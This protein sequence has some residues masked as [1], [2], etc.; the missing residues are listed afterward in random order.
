MALPHTWYLLL[1]PSTSAQPLGLRVA[2]VMT[3]TWEL[4]TI[5]AHEGK[6]EVTHRIF[7]FEAM[8]PLSSKNTPH[9][10]KNLKL[11]IK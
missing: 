9:N 6:A 8:L 10:R 2:G 11:G 3:R 7:A 1:L 5:E 4:H